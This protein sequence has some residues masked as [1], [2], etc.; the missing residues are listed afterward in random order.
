MVDRVIPTMSRTEMIN[1]ILD[2]EGA[3]TRPAVIM[4]RRKINGFL[5]EAP[6][7]VM[8]MPKYIK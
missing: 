6:V 5:A 3:G 1:A 7:E 2:C 8:C 4:T